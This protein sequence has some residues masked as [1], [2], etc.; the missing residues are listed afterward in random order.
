VL[1]GAARVRIPH[2]FDCSR[3][4]MRLIV[5][6]PF[7]PPF[8]DG[9]LTE[10]KTVHA[11][12]HESGDLDWCEEFVTV[13]LNGITVPRAWWPLMTL[14]PE[15][16]GTCAFMLVPQKGSLLPILASVALVALTAGIGAFGVPF[17]G[18]GFAAGTFGASALAAGVGLAGQ[19]AIT[20]LTPPP[21]SPKGPGA[22]RDLSQAGIGQNVVTPFET[23][24]TVHGK[25]RV[26]P[27]IISPFYTT[28]DADE[29]TGHAIG[30]IQGRCLIED[31]LINGTDITILDSVQY[32]TR[33][34]G[35]ADAPLTLAQLTVIQ[36]AAQVTLSNFRTQL[37]ASKN[38]ALLDQTTP[39]NSEP[40]YHPF[41]TDGTPDEIWLRFLLPSG[42]VI[43]SDGTEAAVPIRIE[44]RKLGDS[45]WRKFPTMHIYDN[46]KGSGAFRVEA[47]IK[48]QTQG[49]GRHFSNVNYEYPVFE[50][51]NIT[52]IG[53]S[54]EYAADAYFQHTTWPPTNQIPDMTSN[55]SGGVVSSASTALSGATP[56][57]AAFD[58]DTAT[59]WQP[60]NNSLPAWLQM[61]YASAKTIRSYQIVVVSAN[62]TVSSSVPTVMYVEG[63][64]NGTTWTR[65][66]AVNI[67]ISSL[68]L[69]VGYFQIGT[70]GSYIYYRHNFISNNGA[71]NNQILVAELAHHLV[72]APGMALSA[73]TSIYHG[74]AAR[75]SSGSKPRSVNGSLDKN[76]ATFYLDPA[77]WLPGTYEV[78][79]KRGLAFNTSSFTAT[80]YSWD[81]ATSSD[82]FDYRLSSGVYVARVGQKNYRSDTAV[83]VFSTVSNDV[84]VD[85]AGVACIAVEIKNTQ[86]NSISAIM[87]SYAPIYSG[88]V[89]T[90][91]ETPTSN[92]AALYRKLLLGH[93]NPNPSPG[94]IINEDEL[95]TWYNRCVTAGHECNF[96]QQGRSI[97]EVKQVI[98]ATGYAAPRE[99][100]L[101]SIVEDYNRSAE[102]ITQMLSPLNSK[103]QS[104]NIPLPDLEHALYAEYF[105]AADEWKIKR[106]IFY[107]AGFDA[108]TAQ[109]FTAI[110]YDGFTAAA[111]VAARAAF[112]IKQVV[113]RA[114]RVRLEV[115][116]EFYSLHRGKLVGWNDD[117]LDLKQA[118]GLIRSI[119]TSGGNIVSITVDNVIPFS[120]TQGDVTNVADFSTLT[121]ILDTSVFMGVV[122]RLADGTSIVKTLTNVTDTNICTFTTPFTESGSGV[123]VGQMCVFGVAGREYSRMIVMSVEPQGT[124]SAIVELAAEAPELFT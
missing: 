117:V 38:D 67:D 54:F 9:M 105:D 6:S 22:A 124:E 3:D 13:R 25:M 39:A 92:P 111:K 5:A 63:S 66:D 81:G 65:L 73:D 69:N 110:T 95:A 112:D 45:V 32:E 34:G 108:S 57:W 90:D 37:E 109:F 51:T 55:S 10:R 71:A 99:S 96:L 15:A 103:L 33:E 114:R 48:F 86:I 89:W 31:V 30:G 79:V 91:A 43:S 80:N 101:S 83:E 12:L 77:Q 100:N 26:T 50:L 120:L 20:A 14:K 87:T 24:P 98:A 82:F 94:E 104:V 53:Q 64:N 46:K 102:P 42:I 85:T 36:K 4:L 115:G 60:S 52:G 72:D 28:F 17:L 121:D 35:A 75:H 88:G 70:P 56:A 58:N 18:A 8:Y 116:I 61:Q 44:I 1:A 29:I 106:D 93:A 122:I 78:R 62:N 27:A 97:G 74:N 84:P 107:R 68:P 118:Q 119:E 76:G 19:L 21:S 7:L 41:T 113:A 49:S 59:G 40:D 123:A 47:K 23:L 16:D 11:I 2:S